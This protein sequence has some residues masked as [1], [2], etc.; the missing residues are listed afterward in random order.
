[1]RNHRFVVGTGMTLAELQNTARGMDTA[2]LKDVRVGEKTEPEKNFK[3]VWNENKEH[4][5]A[6]VSGRY[7]LVQ[8]AH[9]LNEVTD[10]LR[11]LNLNARAN[12]RTSG[13]VLI[14][15]VEFPDT[16]LNVAKGEEFVAGMRIINSY[17]KT[18]GIMVLPRLVRL[19]CTNGMV[20]DIGWVKGF[21]VAHTSKLAEDFAQEIPPLLAR[22]VA[23][24][25]KFKT[26]VE[27]CIADSTEWQAAK[28]I[29]QTLIKTDKHSTAIL[30]ELRK[31]GKLDKPSRWDIYNAV[32]SYCTRG[33]QLSP[34][35]ETMLQ[36][37]A[38][39]I[40]VTP[41]ADLL[42]KKEEA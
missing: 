34:A 40:L 18:T 7:N 32:T 15:D 25:A 30:D 19:I 27:A 42:P 17:N 26:Y 20:V 9:V 35:I 24:N 14:C 10:A 23:G 3:A 16:R 39:Q 38:Q 12:V 2:I 37:K 29:V 8:H 28:I 36:N 5:S 33:Q 31:A 13:D 1:M 22:M 4:V 21:N 6:I 41:L 11:N